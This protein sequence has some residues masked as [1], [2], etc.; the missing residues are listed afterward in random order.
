MIRPRIFLKIFLSTV[1][2]IAVTG[3]A[4]TWLATRTVRDSVETETR[5]RLRAQVDILCTLLATSPPTER[6]DVLQARIHALGAR[7]SMRITLIRGDGRV[8][9]DSH[10]DP[11]TMDDHAER[12]EIRA[13]RDSPFGE[14]SRQSQTLGQ[15]MIYVARM[16][17]SET[18]P[19]F[20]VRGSQP[21]LNLDTRLAD[22]RVTVLG[23]VGFAMLLGL[24]GALF[25]A[26]RVSAPLRAVS[27]AAAAI[28]EGD[29]ARRAPVT[30]NDEIGDVGHSFNAMAARLEE[31]V[32]TI[33][34]DQRELRS[35]L[36]GMVEGVLAIDTEERVVLMNEAACEILDIAEEDAAK[37]PIGEAIRVPAVLATL[38]AAVKKQKEQT[39]KVRLPR[40]AID[41]IVKLHA[42]PLLGDD[43][44]ARGAVI[45]LEDVTERE[46][47]ESMR[48]DFI[49]NASHELKTPIASVR[50]MVETILDDE[51][52]DL[53]VRERFLGRVLKQTHRL[54]DIVQ[55]M[56]ALSRLE[57][58]GARLATEAFDARV[59]LREVV[60]DAAPLAGEHA[61]KLS[62]SLPDEACPVLAEP[63]A[64][65]RIVGNLIDNAINYSSQ[66]SQVE[67]HARAQG[68]ELVIEVSDDGPG[69]PTEKHDRI[70]ER[71]Y[72]VDEGRSR[73]VGG[74]GLGLAIVKHLVQALDG[75]I[76]LESAPGQGSTF[77]VTLP[78]A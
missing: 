27:E 4:A 49:A 60:E 29:F 5:E 74:T 63:E 57:T 54:G 1:V 73:E 70:F 55:E 71:F 17:G 15:R 61:V 21:L 76:E 9:A 72:R 75:R 36:R 50:G 56:L 2:L 14:S 69:I 34:R 23:A 78:M 7:T 38:A 46:R 66:G 10:R 51:A 37:R 41:R 33:R 62:S 59:A 8:L 77:R 35:I 32:T 30:T 58:Q 6:N 53:E 64:L 18:A 45:V 42:S 16:V 52:M 3:L 22:L 13:S 48:R 31:E 39:S 20:F 24:L 25:V 28:A 19:K 68:E 43:G 26:R 40:G 11:A 12:A 44:A 65:R 47:V 67:V